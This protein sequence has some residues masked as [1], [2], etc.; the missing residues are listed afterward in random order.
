M[1]QMCR[2]TCVSL[3]RKSCHMCHDTLR[4]HN[5][6]CYVLNCR[7]PILLG[8]CNAVAICNPC[9]IDPGKQSMTV[10]LQCDCDHLSP[11]GVAGN[12]Y[13]ARACL[14]N[15]RLEPLI[16]DFFHG[17]A[18]DCKRVLLPVRPIHSAS[19]KIPGTRH[20]M[21][22][23]HPI[24]SEEATSFMRLQG[25]SRE[26]KMISIVR[27]VMLQAHRKRLNFKIR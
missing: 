23:T 18:A 15:V 12:E 26:E 7:N 5:S 27:K 13:Q 1:A 14:I 4:E 16:P 10:G 17:N 21:S 11:C 9:F 8:S 3:G 20:A 2:Q 24:S 6:R 19:G 25:L 22:R